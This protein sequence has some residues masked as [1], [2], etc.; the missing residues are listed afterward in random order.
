MLMVL[1]KALENKNNPC[2]NHQQF[3]MLINLETLSP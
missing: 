3:N 2:V 1:I